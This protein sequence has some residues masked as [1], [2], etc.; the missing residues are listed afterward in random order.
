MLLQSGSNIPL[1]TTS[2]KD[3]P[4]CPTVSS[5]LFDPITDN[6]FGVSLEKM[7]DD[8]LLSVCMAVSLGGTFFLTNR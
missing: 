8:F 1:H 7:I 2:I 4:L 5:Y 6:G 3:L